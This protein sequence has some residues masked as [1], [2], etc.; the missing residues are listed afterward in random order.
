[1]RNDHRFASLNGAGRKWLTVEELDADRGPY[2]AA[3]PEG[4]LGHDGWS[5]IEG[6]RVPLA[7][8]GDVLKLRPGDSGGAQR[9]H[10]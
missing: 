2:G 7:R 10:D 9:Q 8:L 3:P 5:P 6:R 1:M 4:E